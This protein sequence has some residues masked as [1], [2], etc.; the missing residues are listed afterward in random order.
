MSRL[1]EE[2][3]MTI[4]DDNDLARLKEIGR[5][6]ANTLE[7][8]GKAL[9]PGMSTSELCWRPPV[10]VRLRSWPTTFRAQPASA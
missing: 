10:H 9:E 3:D 6:V 8:M 7:A 1:S 4:S 5:I 2:H